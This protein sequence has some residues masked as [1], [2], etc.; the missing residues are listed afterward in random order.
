MRKLPSFSQLSDVSYTV[1]P[2][3]R[4][5]LWDNEKVSSG[6]LRQVT[7]SKRFNLYENFYD[8]TIKRWP[9][10][11][12]DCL[13]DVTTLAV[14]TVSTESMI[15]LFYCTYNLHIIVLLYIIWMLFCI[16]YLILILNDFFQLSYTN[17]LYIILI[18]RL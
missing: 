16:L 4:S 17:I 6:L 3:L 13:I 18:V 7:S 12:G 10:N 9:F 5:H 8:R 11:T 15:G 2:V 14:L 1:K